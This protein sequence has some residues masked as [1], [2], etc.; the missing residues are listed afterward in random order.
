[1]KNS[2]CKEKN[3][4]HKTI[5]N[6]ISTLIKFSPLSECPLLLSQFHK[7]ARGFNLRSELIEMNLLVFSL[8]L[9][10]IKSDLKLKQIC[11]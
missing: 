10:S 3:Y 6:I 8:V 4:R 5:S 7:V 9:L 2:R 1:M 11:L